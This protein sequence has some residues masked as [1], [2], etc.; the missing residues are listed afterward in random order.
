NSRRRRR[1]SANPGSCRPRRETR[2]REA[3]Q[4]QE[5]TRRSARPMI[6][7][8]QRWRPLRSRPQRQRPVDGGLAY[9]AARLVLSGAAGGDLA[10]QRHGGI[11]ELDATLPARGPPVERALCRKDIDQPAVGG[12][13][14][15]AARQRE[16][17]GAVAAFEIAFGQRGRLAVVLR[18]VDRLFESDPFHRPARCQ[19]EA[20]RVEKREF[21]GDQL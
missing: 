4:P 6:P 8:L 20:R 16:G 9:D 11:E 17:A 12:P 18:R 21:G 10:D 7:E 15:A 3:P 1:S 13:E 5:T 19:R 14:L 2:D